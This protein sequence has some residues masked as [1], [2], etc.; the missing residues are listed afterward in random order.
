MMGDIRKN[1]RMIPLGFKTME[2]FL[3]AG[4]QLKEIILK[5]QHN[6]KSTKVWEGRN[7]KFLLLAHEYIF[8]FE[9]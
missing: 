3:K 9:K 2:C 1:G 7:N 4:F 5:E 8:V 6:C